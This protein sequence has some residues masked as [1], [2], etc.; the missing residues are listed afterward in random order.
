MSS[1]NSCENRTETSLS[2]HSS[3]AIVSS[4][5]S[6]T[7]NMSIEGMSDLMDS[8]I[9]IGSQRSIQSLTA[10]KRK[11]SDAYANISSSSRFGRTTNTKPVVKNP[12]Q[13]ALERQRK[14]KL[15]LFLL[16]HSSACKP[17]C[18]RDNLCQSVNCSKMKVCLFFYIKLRIYK[19]YHFVGIYK[20]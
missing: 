18:G 9:S 3:I 19:F 16:Q 8:Q 17:N 10:T 13:E 2:N 15:H 1:F 4:S 11:I 14:I 12:D 6:E 5:S 7:E 20:T